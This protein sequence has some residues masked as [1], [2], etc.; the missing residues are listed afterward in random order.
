MGDETI[1]W[2]LELYVLAT[3]M[4][5]SGWVPIYDSAHSWWLYS[6]APVGDQTANTMTRC[7]SK[8]HYPN[9]EPASP[10]PILI[11]KMPD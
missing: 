10:C 9:T 6:T 8:L 5:I 2:L 1:G 3:S 7:P 4:V 11:I